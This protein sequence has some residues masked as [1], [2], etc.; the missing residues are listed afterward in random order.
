MTKIIPELLEAFRQLSEGESKWP[1]LLYGPPGTGKTCASLAL[2]DYC[3][4]AAY[5][6]TDQLRDEI[7]TRKVNWKWIADSSLAV[8]D[9]LALR[10]DAKD[11][12]YTAVKQFADRRDHKPTIYIT[13]VDPI[14]L[15]RIYDDRVHSRVCCGTWFHLSGEDRRMK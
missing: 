1:L 10:T 6:T 14:D 3:A 13:N 5:R 9:E 7:S 4:T 8:L 2:C 11:F 15:A 12:D